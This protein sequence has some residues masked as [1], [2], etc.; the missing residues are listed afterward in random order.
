MNMPP[1][2]QRMT[3]PLL[4]IAAGVVTLAFG[5][6]DA[7]RGIAAAIGAVL[8]I[9][10]WFALRWLAQR[11]STGT[12]GNGAALSLLLIAK[13]GLLMAVVFVLIGRLGVDPIGLAF[14]LG[15]LFVGPVLSALLT[16]SNNAPHEAAM[17]PAVRAAREER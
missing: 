14:G 1:P 4:L 11:L 15:V 5:L 7:T 12:Q 3:K 16:T 17:N 2:T 10:N 8:S 13:I 9:G 6:W